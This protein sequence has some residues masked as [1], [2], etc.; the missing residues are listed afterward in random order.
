MP[1]INWS[2]G[3]TYQIQD[4]QGT[5]ITIPELPTST[6]TYPSGVTITPT[7]TLIFDSTGQPYNSSGTALTSDFNL[8][9]TTSDTTQIVTV[10]AQT[11]FIQ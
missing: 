9:V 11:G 1:V 2:S 6:T 4:A 7:T 3:R 10:S 8:M 5:A